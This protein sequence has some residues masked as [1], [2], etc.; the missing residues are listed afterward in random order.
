[1]N[2]ASTNG[3]E[4]GLFT[5][6]LEMVH[7]KFD[8]STI[9]AEWQEVLKRHAAWMKE[10]PSIMVQVEGHTD[11]RG[12]EEYNIALGQRRADAVR[13]FLV[14]DAGVDPNRI[15]TISYGKMRP[16]TWEQNEESHALNRRAMFLVYE[17]DN[18]VASAW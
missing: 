16:L 13:T 12:T 9:T 4:S 7:F 18:S 10:H 6:E 17:I 2:T 5:A 3:V 11:E 14:E 1:M 8:D 15:S